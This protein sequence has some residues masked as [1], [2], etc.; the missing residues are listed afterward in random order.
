MYSDIMS[1]HIRTI[2][3]GCLVLLLLCAPC[4]AACPN[5]YSGSAAKESTCPYATPSCDGSSCS[6]CSGNSDTSS[7]VYGAFKCESGNCTA[8]VYEDGNYDSATYENT[9]AEDSQGAVVCKDGTC[10]GKVC[11]DSS[12]ETGSFS[13]S[14]SLKSWFDSIFGGSSSQETVETPTSTT[15]TVPETTTS[16][17]NFYGDYASSSAT[18][19]VVENTTPVA[20]EDETPIAVEDTTPVEVETP[21]CNATPTCNTCAS[22]QTCSTC[23]TCKNTSVVKTTCGNTTGVAS[24]TTVY[25]ALK[26]DKTEKNI[27]TDNYTSLN[28][29]QDVC[30]AMSKQGIECTICKA[31]FTD[32]KVSY[33]NK[34]QTDQGVLNVDSCGTAS[35]TGIK[36]VINTLEVGKQWKATSLFNQCVKPYDKGIVASIECL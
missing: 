22:G 24:Y 21:S 27:L 1:T 17:T 12:C 30:T 35:G 10:Q 18:P 33:Y 34:F 20:V 32:G 26:A 16:S 15:Y 3:I 6:T 13:I 28:F 8:K 4:M 9:G 5:S 7:A 36:K 11:N 23:S 19:E 14:G 2:T 25:N 31:T 29:A